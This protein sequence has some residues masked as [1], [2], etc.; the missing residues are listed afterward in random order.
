MMHDVELISYC[1]HFF[2]I[3]AKN[4]VG[5]YDIIFGPVLIWQFKHVKH[6][7]NL[8]PFFLQM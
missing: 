8:H 2:N 7:K 6:Y 3:L 4:K 1:S 5:N